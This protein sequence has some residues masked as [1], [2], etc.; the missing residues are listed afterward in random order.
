MASCSLEVYI[1]IAKM[2]GMTWLANRTGANEMVPPEPPEA[3]QRSRAH[4]RDC[5]VCQAGRGCALAV[6]AGRPHPRRI[7]AGVGMG[8]PPSFPEPARLRRTGALCDLP[9]ALHA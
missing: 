7:L 1:A 5:R 8:G 4:A 3:S 9:H 6:L 2:G